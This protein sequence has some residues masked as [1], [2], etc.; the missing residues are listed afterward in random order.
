[1]ETAYCTFT[2]LPLQ[3]SK[4]HFHNKNSES[5]GL[6]DKIAEIEAE[7]ARTQKNKATEHHLGSLK[8]KLARYRS[9]LAEPKQKSTKAP[10]FE[11]QKSGDARV[12]LVG[13]PSVGK[14]TLLSKI[15]STFSKQAEHEFTTLD[16]ISGKL[17]YNGASIQILDL[18]GIIDGASSNRG[19]GRQIIS[20]VK[21]ADLILMI[22]DY[23][24][25]KDKEILISELNKMGIRI[26]KTRPNVSLVRTGS[27]IEITACCK[28][29]NLSEATIIAIL[30]E[31][32][33]YNCQLT[34]REDITDE[35]LID[36]LSS[37]ATYLR[38]I[39]CYNK[40]DELSYDEFLSIAEDD[41]NVVI[42]CNMG[43]NLDE[44]KHRVWS[45]LQLKRIY[46]KK[47]GEDPDFKHPIVM[48]SEPT[49]KELCL[50]I[51]KD[52]DINF[53][54]ALVWGSS[55]KHQPQKVGLS[56]FLN[57]EDVVQISTK[58]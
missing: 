52:M 57:D 33:I 27:G 39:F 18:P 31:Y 38:C 25:P 50:R 30:K 12:A 32:R 37:N 15:T 19:R 47:K 6:G 40:V 51:H 14:S 54:H 48:R 42:S 58:Y 44:L 20:V 28:L 16:C 7:M 10:A 8:A 1:M 4:H 11:V 46:T 49:V 5:M 41:E 23:R 35:D 43:W 9:E 26:N 2:P 3:S 13:F 21:T 29:A 53:K 22:L 36:V 34:I 45:E 56:H 17:E 55:A 24:R